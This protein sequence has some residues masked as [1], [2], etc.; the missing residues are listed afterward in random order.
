MPSEQPWKDTYQQNLMK[1]QIRL[2]GAFIDSTPDDDHNFKSAFRGG[3]HYEEAAYP[4]RIWY[5]WQSPEIVVAVG[6]CNSFFKKYFAT[7]VKKFQIIVSDDCM[8]WIPFALI[9]KSGFKKP[10]QCQTW[11]IPTSNQAQYL[12]YGL[13]IDGN[14]GTRTALRKIAMWRA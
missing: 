5:C 3:W 7:S 8:T 14:V 4:M 12:C 9:Q 13:Q 1:Y 11:Q 10:N 2:P 6:F